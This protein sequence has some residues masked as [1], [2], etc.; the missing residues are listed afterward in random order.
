MEYKPELNEKCMPFLH[1]ISSIEITSYKYLEDS[2]TSSY[3][4]Y[5]FTLAFTSADIIFQNF[6]E[7]HS[8]LSEE[9]FLAKVFFF[10]PIHFPFFSPIQYYLIQDDGFFVHIC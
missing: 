1:C 5:C 4:S 2:V 8:V 10:S 7:L 9:S 6:I 3:I